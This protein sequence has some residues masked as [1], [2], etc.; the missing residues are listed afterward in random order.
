MPYNAFTF[1]STLALSFFLVSCSGKRTPDYNPAIGPFDEDGNYIEAW[2]DNPPKRNRFWFSKKKTEEP[3]VVE[4]E[5]PT[6][7]VYQKPKQ[8]TRP[9][10]KPT[11]RPKPKV[12]PKPVKVRPKSRR[13]KV[14]K[15]DTLYGLSRRYGVSVS[16]IQRANKMSGTNIR[17]G[18][19]LLIPAK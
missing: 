8:A 9:E 16:A 7:Q 15:G 13:H 5:K 2:A 18:A 4:N 10:P 14:A 6:R 3:K 19:T 12:K 17:I 1:I 11:Y